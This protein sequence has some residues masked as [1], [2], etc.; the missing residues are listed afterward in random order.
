L[1]PDE[2]VVNVSGFRLFFPERRLFFTEAA[3]IFDYGQSAG[4][5]GGDNPLLQVYCSRRSVHSR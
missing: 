4:L 2:E 3:M 1:E 5:V